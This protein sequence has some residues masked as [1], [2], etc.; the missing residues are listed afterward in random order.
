M[1]SA[2]AFCRWERFGS[3]IFLLAVRASGRD[4]QALPDFSEN[5]YAATEL[6]TYIL[7][8]LFTAAVLLKPEGIDLLDALHLR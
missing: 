1:C 8:S 6:I 2:A 7:A 4:Q 3:R 5:V